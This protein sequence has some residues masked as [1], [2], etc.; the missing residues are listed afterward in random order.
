MSTAPHSEGFVRRP[1]AEGS[2]RS[3]ETQKRKLT[4]QLPAPPQLP[5]ATVNITVPTQTGTV[6]NVTVGKVASLTAAIKAATCGDTVVLP[7]GSTWAMTNS[8]NLPNLNCTGWVLIESSAV[9]ELPA[10]TRVGFQPGS[11]GVFNPATLA[12]MATVTMSNITP[13]FTFSAGAHNWWFIGLEFSYIGSG[14][15]SNAL[16]CIDS[17]CAGDGTQRTLASQ[18]NNIIVDRCY[19]HGTPTTNLRR[20]VAINGAYLAVVDSYI[21][22]IHEAGNGDTQAIA[23]WNG[24]GPV[25]IQNNFLSSAGENFLYGGA[26]NSIPGM[27]PSDFTVVGNYFWKNPAWRNQMCC[28]AKNILEFKDA[29]RII[30]RGNVFFNNW[31]NAQNGTAWLATPRN[32]PC[33]TNPQS[34]VQDIT[35][36]YNV[37]AH[38]ANGL[39]VGPTDNECLGTPP[40]GSQ[41]SQRLLFS[42]N[43]FWDIDQSYGNGTGGVGWALYIASDSA[44]GY[45]NPHDITFDHNDFFAGNVSFDSAG[46]QPPYGGAAD[47]IQYTNDIVANDVLGTGTGPGASTLN[48]FYTNLTWNKVVMIGG[49]P[50]ANYPKTT[51]FPAVGKVGFTHY[52]P[53]TMHNF[54]CPIGDLQLTNASRYHNAGT[55][56]KDIGVWDWA[57]FNADVNNALNGT[58]P[59]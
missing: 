26:K 40:K 32:Q 16:I 33:G 57:T 21:S 10:G 52:I 44:A 23:G 19:I 25:L 7:A 1:L 53:C 54:L 55:D 29:Q 11:V 41:P 42:N 43:L 36:A 3:A 15:L 12:N 50:G 20:G 17:D 2:L 31:F 28:Q 58:F 51:F 56:G 37:L 18:P 8:I 47:K 38:T 48:M 30:V 39:A 46:A 6:R 35:Y 9:A 49:S 14:D 27:I 24:S 4:T 45:L 59:Y 13:F 34:T 22:D 5:R